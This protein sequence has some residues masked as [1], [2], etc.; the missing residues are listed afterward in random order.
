MIVALRRSSGGGSSPAGARAR[1]VAG[2]ERACRT[3]CRTSPPAGSRRR[4][5]GS[6]R[7]RARRTTCRT[8]RPR[9]SRCRSSRRSCAAG[10]VRARSSRYS[11]GISSTRGRRRRPRPRRGARG[12]GRSSSASSPAPRAGPSATGRAAPGV[13]VARRTS[14]PRQIGQSSTHCVLGCSGVAIGRRRGLEADLE[15]AVVELGA[16]RAAAGEGGGQD[17]SSLRAGRP[18]RS[19]R[20]RPSSAPISPFSP[21]GTGIRSVVGPVR[22]TRSPGRARCAAPPPASSSSPN[23]SSPRRSSIRAP[24]TSSSK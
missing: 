1:R 13:A 16:G 17:D 18:R 24:T 20:R 6:R 4:S 11:I 23:S 12:S 2:A 8:A 10:Y 21:N 7:Q 9:D 14:A 15:R 5:S 22:P 19:A 3:R